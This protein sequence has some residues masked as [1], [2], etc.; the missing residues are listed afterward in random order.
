MLKKLAESVREYKKPAIWTLI[1]ILGEAVIE[2]IIPFVT[3]DL[4]NLVKA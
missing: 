3:A 2:T 4:V 1:L